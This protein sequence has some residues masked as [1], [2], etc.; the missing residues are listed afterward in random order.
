MKHHYI[1]EDLA[2]NILLC[3]PHGQELKRFGG[4][5]ALEEALAWAQT[6]NIEVRATPK[7]MDLG[8]RHPFHIR[9]RSRSEAMLNILALEL[10][11]DENDLDVE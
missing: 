5:Q 6:Q 9:R 8:D 1:E 10:L 3:D 4:S 11:L 7:P 2:G